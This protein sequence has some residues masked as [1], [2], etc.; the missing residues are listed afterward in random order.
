MAN[1]FIIGGDDK[2]YGPISDA[3]VR[4]WIAEGRLNA[5]SRAKA[6]SDAEFRAL[7]Q[8]PEFAAALAPQAATAPVAPIRT[9]TDFLERDYELDLGGCISRGWELFKENFGILF[10]ACLIMFAVQ[11]GFMFALGLITAP[12]TK[13]LMHTPIVVQVGFKFLLPVVTSLVIGPMSGGIYFVFLKKIRQQGAGAGDVFAGFQTAFAQLYL[14]A[15]VVGL[16]N[17]ACM[18]P[19][20]F[21]WQTK[22]GP[23]LEQMQHLQNDPAGMQNLLPQLMPAFTSALPVLLICLVPVTF[24]TVCWLFTLPL[25]MDKQMDFGAAM[26][27]SW[28]MVTKHWWQV[29][30][31]TVLAGLVSL[32]GVLGCCIGVLFTAPIGIAAM[33]FAYETIF[34]AEKN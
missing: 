21:V 7:A 1:Y 31:L 8:F 12:V 32:A 4:L 22:T 18:L 24:F 27:T 13:I 2:E 11:F 6:E 23:L 34:G 15:L 30:G 29:F 17:G 33:M 26:K 10:V 19:F 16:I 14:G 20:Q 9:A 25:I 5:T 28:K 3:D